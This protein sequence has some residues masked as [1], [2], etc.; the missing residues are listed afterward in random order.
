MFGSFFSS[1]EDSGWDLSNEGDLEVLGELMCD[2]DSHL[3]CDESGS[4]ECVP[5]ED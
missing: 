5:D 1:N 2:H 4:C 3:E